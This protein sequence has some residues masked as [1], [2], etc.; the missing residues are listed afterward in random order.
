MEKA[1]LLDI[2]GVL[3]DS[4]VANRKMHQKLIELVCGK[5]INDETIDPFFS[6]TLK[7]IAR[8]FC[9]HLS[10]AKLAT[11]LQLGIQLYPQFYPFLKTEENLIKTIKTLSKNYLLGIVTGRLTGEVLEYLKINHYFQTIITA[12]DY[13]HPKPYPQPLLLAL[14][15]LKVAPESSVYIGDSKFDQEAAKAARIHFLAF[16]N[17]SLPTKHHLNKL[18]QLPKY[19]KRIFKT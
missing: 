1:V 16:R 13:R 19:L 8:R 2:D 15:K 4:K 11:A 18:S 9:P 10:E 12:Q 7:E 14:K 17:P 3:I 5:K 6:H